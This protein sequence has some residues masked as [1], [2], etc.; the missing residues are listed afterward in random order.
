LEQPIGG[1]RW[2]KA[3]QQQANIDNRGRRPH[4]PNEARQTLDDVAGKSAKWV[5]AGGPAVFFLFFNPFS[6]GFHT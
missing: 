6:K 4:E 1:D 5:V 2:A 3:A